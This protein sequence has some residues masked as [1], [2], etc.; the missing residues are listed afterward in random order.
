MGFDLYAWPIDGPVTQPEA[1]AELERLLDYDHP[2]EAADSRLRAFVAEL[3]A[4]FPAGFQDSDVVD[5]QWQLPDGAVVFELDGFHEHV[6]LGIPWPFVSEVGAAAQ[7]IA[8]NYDL[9]LYDPQS[10]TAILSPKFGGEPADWATD[11]GEVEALADEI[12]TNLEVDVS[13]LDL[14]DERDAM[15][16]L[17]REVQ[18]TGGR[19]EVAMGIEVTEDIVAELLPTRTDCLRSFRRQ[20][21]RPASWRTFVRR[22]TDPGWRP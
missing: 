15:R 13:D 1:A 9:L 2:G 7:E 10:E 5:E 21:R 8:F 14:D 3:K 20:R 4:R 16:A 18:A 6:F 12:A 22:R 19:M 11:D 17:V